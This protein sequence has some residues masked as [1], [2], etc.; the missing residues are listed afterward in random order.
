[1]Q[2]IPKG[3]LMKKL[4]MIIAALAMTALFAQANEMDKVK[5]VAEDAVQQATESAPVQ[6]QTEEN[7]EKAAEQKTEEVQ[8]PEKH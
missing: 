3:Y 4:L 6:K 8:T 2:T 1:M 7:A 5:A